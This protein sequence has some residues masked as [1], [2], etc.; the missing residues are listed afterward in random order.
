MNI[1]VMKEFWSYCLSS[2]ASFLMQ[3]PIVYF[4]GLILLAYV[5]A[6]LTNNFLRR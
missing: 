1:E 6:I 2:F 3:E 5:V 4:T